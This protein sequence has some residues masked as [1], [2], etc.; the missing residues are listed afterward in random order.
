MEIGFLI[1]LIFVLA[2]LARALARTI[3]RRGL[4]N[5]RSEAEVKQALQQAEQRLTDSETRLAALEER[6]DFYE[7]LLANPDRK[8]A[9]V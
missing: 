1:L 2:P 4:P 6:V 9:G 7:R 3:E 5:T 8:N